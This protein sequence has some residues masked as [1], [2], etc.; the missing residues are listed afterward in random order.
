MRYLVQMAISPVQYSLQEFIA[1]SR[2]LRDLWYSSWLISEVSKS[3]ALEMK[4]H[5][6]LIF[7]SSSANLLPASAT[8]VANKVVAEFTGSEDSLKELM[9]NIEKVA[10][11]KMSHVW[12]EVVSHKLEGLK[13]HLADSQITDFL[14]CTWAALPFLDDTSSA[15]ESSRGQLE[16]LM[17]ATKATRPFAQPTWGSSRA[18]SSL[19]G[20]YESVLPT[21]SPH[22]QMGFGIRTGEELSAIDLLKRLGTPDQTHQYFPSTTHMAVVPFLSQLAHHQEAPIVE[23]WKRYESLLKN[24]FP[25]VYRHEQVGGDDVPEKVFA[26]AKAPFWGNADGSLFFAERI[27]E[28]ME[29]INPGKGKETNAQ[30]IFDA[31]EAFYHTIETTTHI[32]RPRQYY[33][34]LMADGDNM[35]SVIH[36]LAQDKDGIHQHQMFSQT[37]DQFAQKAREIIREHQGAAVYTGGDDVLA[38]LPL[39]KALACARKLADTFYT[40]LSEHDALKNRS[41]TT[42]LSAGLAIIHHLEPLREALTLARAAEKDSK[43]Y[44]SLS[45]VRKNALTISLQKRSGVPISVTG[46]WKQI[47][48]RLITLSNW[49][50]ADQLPDGYAYELRALANRFVP[51]NIGANALTPQQQRS[52]NDILIHESIRILKRK[53]SDSAIHSEMEA[54]LKEPGT[55]VADIA[56][57]LLVARV[58]AD[59]A[60]RMEKGV[61]HDHMDH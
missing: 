40:M 36:A 58:F 14:E 29:Q 35:G 15:Y 54:L 23:A 34:I 25:E 21:L 17:A 38:I 49:L 60:Y 12:E 43:Q 16:R 59:A 26:L 33:G 57:Q 48:T 28:G 6:Q 61:P 56:D 51:T 37:L 24:H 41:V 11:D 44:E 45:G 5:A 13:L 20:V 4:D 8:S 52:V 19:D 1:N 47:D 9:A 7:P 42:T 2:R 3:V 10:Y 50:S 46:H 27:R 32:P 53:D 18:K 31:L 22:I 55:H 30:Q 39:H